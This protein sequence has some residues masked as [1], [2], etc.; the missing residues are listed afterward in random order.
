MAASRKRDRARR[1]PWTRRTSRSPSSS[2]SRQAG[3]EPGRARRRRCRSSRAT[4][5]PRV[6]SSS[7]RHDLHAGQ[8]PQ[9]RDERAPATC[10]SGPP[11]AR[12]RRPPRCSHR[13]VNVLTNVRSSTTPRSMRATP[14]AAR[15]PPRPPPTRARGRGRGGSGCRRARRPRGTPRSA[16]TWAA[17][18]SVPSPPAA[19]MTENAGSR[20]SAT[21]VVALLELDDVGGRELGPQLVGGRRGPRRPR[22]T[23]SRRC[24]RRRRRARAATSPDRSR[25]GSGVGASAGRA[26]STRWR[27]HT[28]TATASARTPTRAHPPWRAHGR[29]RRRRCGRSLSRML[30]RRSSPPSAASRNST[31]ATAG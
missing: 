9:Q 18:P 21:E 12:G 22:R 23:G 14:P 13:S 7:R 6:P 16:A 31:I 2:A 30:P 26:G 20:R 8:L 3:A 11:G 15:P 27:A 10:P 4:R 17:A 1:P 25:C 24:A 29:S 28:S 5:R 19:P